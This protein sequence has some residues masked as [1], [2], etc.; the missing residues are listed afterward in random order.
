[1]VMKNKFRV[2]LIGCGA[3]APNHLRAI[4]DCDQELCALCDINTD[5]AEALKKR[6]DLGD[7]PI[8]KSYVDMLE[9][10]KPDSVHICTP[11]YLHAEMVCE[12][13]SRNVHVLCE[14]P[15][16][17]SYSELDKIEKAVA[18]SNAVLGVCHQ[19]RYEDNMLILHDLAK[20]GIIGGVGYMLWKRDA[21]Y[22]A[23]AEWRGTNDMEGGG[24]LINQAL[25]TLDLLTWV[26]GMPKYVTAHTTCDSLKDVIE[27]EDTAFMRFELPNGTPLNFFATNACGA[28][29]NPRLEVKLAD[30]RRVNASNKIITVDNEVLNHKA[31]EIYSGKAVWGAG[32]TKLIADFYQKIGNGEKFE[33]GFEEASKVIRL[34]LATY[35]S[36]GQKIEI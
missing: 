19:N 26:C 25:H 22:Y 16:C 36:D 13:L 27:V 9:T 1:M 34:I 14:K 24:V 8:Y 31:K 6:F 35:R 5:H 10:E 28:D 32:H 33:L 12:T 17:I 7:V 30:N 3:I 4:I 23:S 11:H 20:D 15:L 2:A 29:F 21:D 18:A